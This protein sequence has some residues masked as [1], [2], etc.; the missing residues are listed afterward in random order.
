MGTSLGSKIKEL[1]KSKGYSFDKLARLA[2]TSKS[3][4]WNLETGKSVKPS[5]RKLLKISNSLGVTVDFLIDDEDMIAVED[6]AD[7][8]FYRKYRKLNARDKLKIR[9]FIDVFL[10]EES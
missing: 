7:A 2:G 9:K 1:R 4:I 3:Y 6:A 8:S 10:T 5:A